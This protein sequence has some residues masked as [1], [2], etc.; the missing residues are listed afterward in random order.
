MDPDLRVLRPSSAPFSWKS[1]P[2]FKPNN[3]DTN[4]LGAPQETGVQRVAKQP[5]P[6]SRAMA[7]NEDATDAKFV[8][9]LQQSVDLVVRV[10]PQNLRAQLTREYRIVDQRTDLPSSESSAQT[11]HYGIELGVASTHGR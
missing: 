4:A 7:S 5:R 11:N 10:E 3:V 2:P 9:K 1:V 6:Q 8:R